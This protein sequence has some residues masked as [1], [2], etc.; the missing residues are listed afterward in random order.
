LS[1]FLKLCLALCLLFPCANVGAKEAAPVFGEN[2]GVSIKLDRI[3]ENDIQKIA[4]LGIRGVRTGINWHQVEREKGV[5]DWSLPLPR[6][7][8]A[9]D[10]RQHRTTTYDDLIALL[11]KHGLHVSI[12]LGEGNSLYTGPLVSI[13]WE[14]SYL[15]APPAPRTPEAIAAF[16]AFAAATAAHYTESYGPDA[17]TWLIWNEPDFDFNFPPQTDGGA[18]GRVLEQACLGI[19]AAVPQARVIGP[20]LSVTGNGAFHYDFIKNLFLKANPLTC[21]DAFTL[22]PYRPTPPETAPADYA[23][24]AAFISAW[25]PQKTVPIAVDE[26]GITTTKPD[27]DNDEASWRD[28][29]QD[30][31][32]ALLLRMVLINLAAGLPYT[33]LYEWQDSGD[34]PDEAEANYGMNTAAGEE[35]PAI[36]MFRYVWPRLSGRELHKD[37]AAEGCAA[38]AHLLRFTSP[39][40]HEPDIIVAWAETRQ[41]GLELLTTSDAAFDLFGNALASGAPLPLG[42]A[43]ILIDA[44]RGKP[45]SLK[46]QK[47]PKP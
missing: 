6:D 30:E 8:A 46:C 9:L 3:T 37:V 43:P 2:F 27:K 13:P 18:V 26:W 39:A 36:R 23:K 19:K 12:L 16:A 10:F 41:E 24:M 4:A 42:I 25:Q 31:Q 11:R 32:A 28:F 15:R 14:G 1:R 40:S 21:L 45:L 17:F 47:T 38:T 33:A 29:S 44:P 5:Y 20:A 7:R 35:K 22:H 34:D